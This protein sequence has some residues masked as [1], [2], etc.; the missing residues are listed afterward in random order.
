MFAALTSAILWG[1]LPIYW[2]ALRPIDS[3]VI[4]FYRIVLVGV[5]CFVA[6]LKV[7]GRKEMLK[8]LKH[9]KTVLIF[10]LAGVLITTNWSIYIWAVNAN[11]VIQ[12]CIGYYIEPLMVSAFGIIFFKE[13]LNRSKLIALTLALVG[14][15]MLLFYFGEFPAVALA[16]AVTFATYAAIKKGVQAPPI[17]ALLYET[18][19]LLPLALVV[20]VYLELTGR[21]ALGVGEPYQYGLLLL[22]GIM[23]AIPL[24]F[25]GLAANKIPLVSLGIIE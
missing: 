5:V 8:P 9:K 11:L 22:A 6:A 4:I 3:F 16:L 21:G 15:G 20:I 2:Q 19:F 25:F 18:I 12:T 7:Y 14:L 17:L 23:T 24:G 10:F 13:G 1:V